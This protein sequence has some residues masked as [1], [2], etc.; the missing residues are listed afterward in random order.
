MG[1]RQPSSLGVGGECQQWS[2]P[3]GS[4]SRPTSLQRSVYSGC[5][6]IAGCGWTS[7]FFPPAP[8]TLPAVRCFSPAG[9]RET[10]ALGPGALDQEPDAPCTPAAALGAGLPP[11]R[12]R[13][14]QG[15]TRPQPP[16][17]Y[18]VREREQHADFVCVVWTP[19]APQPWP[20]SST[21]GRCGRCLLLVR[22]GFG[23]SGQ[24][25]AEVTSS[26]GSRVS[27]VLSS[28]PAPPPSRVWNDDHPVPWAGPPTFS[29]RSGPRRPLPARLCIWL[30][31][32][33]AAKTVRCADSGERIRLQVR[34]TCTAPSFRD[35]EDVTAQP[36][37]VSRVG[38]PPAPGTGR[39][40]GPHSPQWQQQRGGRQGS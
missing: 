30:C 2:C 12:P 33:A 7:Y 6:S 25:G 5:L 29:P 27:G 22:V 24:R 19:L 15:G 16:R 4:L 40:V 36:L 17:R 10:S 39:Q 26:S 9:G 38:N 21:L 32:A 20:P 1:R 3:L 18:R 28:G 14:L 35:S 23:V 31:A 34:N 37:R 8:H 11:R 13:G